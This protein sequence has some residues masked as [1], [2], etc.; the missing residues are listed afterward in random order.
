MRAGKVSHVGTRVLLQPIS[1]LAIVHC[2]LHRQLMCGLRDFSRQLGI[3]LQRLQ[4]LQQPRSQGP[5][6]TSRKSNSKNTNLRHVEVKN[7]YSTRN[8]F[9]QFQR[10]HILQLDAAQIRSA[11]SFSLFPP[12]TRRLS[13]LFSF[14]NTCKG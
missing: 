5:L 13:K 2:P 11:F 8:S 12:Q 4:G 1:K 6:S 14:I 9:V 10:L 3:L 7:R